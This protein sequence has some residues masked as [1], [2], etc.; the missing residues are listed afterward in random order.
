MKT[1][2][3]ARA[4]ARQAL[5]DIGGHYDQGDYDYATAQWIRSYIK[6]GDVSGLVEFFAEQPDQRIL[7]L[8][9]MVADALESSN[10]DCAMRLGDYMAELGSDYIAAE[11]EKIAA[12]ME[13]AA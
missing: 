6:D 1:Y 7:N 3:N 9:A 13:D 11:V 10:S 5:Y 4:A 12:N 8:M 2:D